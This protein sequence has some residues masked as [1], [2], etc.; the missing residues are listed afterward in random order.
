MTLDEIKSAVLAGKV[1]CW[2]NSGYQVK[3][4][5]VGNWSIVHHSG[6]LIGLTWMDGVTINGKPDEFFIFGE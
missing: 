6:G 1:V 3:V 4:D 2:S 5:K